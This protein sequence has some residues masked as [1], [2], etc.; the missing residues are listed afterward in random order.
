MLTA[1]SYDQRYYD[2]HR[3]EGLD[4]ASYGPWQQEYGR[5]IVDG[6]GLAGR[7]VLDV[8]CACGAIAAGIH[9]AG[10]FCC[11]G[12]DLNE[13]MIAIGRKQF[14]AVRLW[15]CDAVN[16]HL[17]PHACF[18]AIH[19]AQVAEHWREDLVPAILRELARVTRPGGK[20]F[21][22]LDTVELFARQGRTLM[23][24]DPTHICIKPLAWWREQLAAA[25]W[26]VAEQR[27]PQFRDHDWDF[28]IAERVS[29]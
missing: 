9:E 19:S 15:T 14:P 22:C 27:L 8:G 3:T 5:W 12:V 7:V 20:F 24:E 18:D 21:L 16:L 23:N 17:F 13:H 2:E 28:L 11:V 25:G 26:R 10:A 29:T 4:Y 6:L 1:T